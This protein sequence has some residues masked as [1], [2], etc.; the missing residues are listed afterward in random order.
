[1]REQVGTPLKITQIFLAKATLSEASEEVD[2]NLLVPK[3]LVDELDLT[4]FFVDSDHAHDK[5]STQVCDRF[6]CIC[7]KNACIVY[8]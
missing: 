6:D 5:I 2:C 3:P 1:M 7:W 4:V 8:E